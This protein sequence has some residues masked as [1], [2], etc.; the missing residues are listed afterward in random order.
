M[1]VARV[2][3]SGVDAG[4]IGFRL[5]PRIN[6]AGRL[7]RADA[8]LELLLTAD[9]QRAR[10]IA[11]EL[12]AVEH[13]AARRRDA[14]PV[15]GGG[16]GGSD[17]AGRGGVRARRRRLAPRGDRHRGVPDR[18]APPPAGGADRPRRGSGHRLRPLHPRLRPARRPRGGER[19]PPAPRRPPR[20]GGAD[21]R[22][23][24]R[25]RVPGRLRGPRGRR[26]ATGG[27]RAAPARRRRRPGRR[28]AHRPRRGARAPR[29]V[30]DGQ[31]GAVPARPQRVAGR[32]APAR[33]RP[34]RRVRPGGGRRPV[35]LRGLR[36][37]RRPPRGAGQRR[38]TRRSAWRSTATT[39]PSSRAWSCATPARP[40]PAPITVVGE[41]GFADAVLAELDRPLAAAAGAEAE[42]DR[43]PA[44]G[45][46][47]E[48]ELHRGLGP[49]TD[50][51][52]LARQPRPGR[53]ARR[54]I[55]DSRDGG[56]AGL[57]GDL[58]AGGG[59]VLAVA[60]HAERRARA[61][62]NR[63]GGFAVTSW[64]ALEAD[65]ALAAR[66]RARR[67]GRPAV[68]RARCGRWPPA[69]RARAG[70]ISPG[71]SRSASSRAGCWRGS[72]I[73]GRISRPSIARC[74]LR[75]SS[76]AS[77][78]PGCCAGRR[79]RRAPGRSPGGC[80]ACSRSWDSSWSSARRSRSASCRA[81]RAPSSSAR[82]RS[83][84]TSAGWPTV[85]AAL[86][87][88]PPAAQPAAQATARRA[89]TGARG[90][91]G[92]PRPAATATFAYGGLVG[93]RSE[94]AR[95]TFSGREIAVKAEYVEVL[96][97]HASR[98]RRPT[99][100][101]YASARYRTVAGAVLGPPV[102]H[103]PA[104]RPPDGRWAGAPR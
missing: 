77:R 10:A 48:A 73:C 85:L 1:E 17:A 93:R 66:Q 71:A 24:A 74:S 38:S 54:E 89:R 101:P 72:W 52:G 49:P 37:R 11:A 62:Q 36:A 46:G 45:G 97:P 25:G 41:P 95:G 94:P 44:P 59:S 79:R 40:Q 87:T 13:G 26:P 18:R 57:L 76:R 15:R 58:V 47:G 65:P 96:Q 50:P 28:P 3:P 9:V 84:L 90:L 20:R 55:C 12:D 5:A 103:H 6:A 30:R 100:Q 31:P 16:A 86:G 92:D 14:D 34:P 21:D 80:C 67:R 99:S 56:I 4:A 8:G 83:G 32:P 81:R 78:S 53:V 91:S 29:A 23:R 104:Q 2:D 33:R 70:R 19:R 75:P 64:A 22:A 102:D 69:C 98:T 68:L 35:A 27:S 88:R 43:P 60:A 51:P 61:L 7:H 39:A 42:L 63:V 82:P